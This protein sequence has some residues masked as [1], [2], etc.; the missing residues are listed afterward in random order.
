[1]Q[2]WRAVK[3]LLQAPRIDPILRLWQQLLASDLHI[4]AGGAVSPGAVGQNTVDGPTPVVRLQRW[5][6]VVFLCLLGSANQTVQ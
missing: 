3:Q 5:T 2:R 4:V 1:M 6:I